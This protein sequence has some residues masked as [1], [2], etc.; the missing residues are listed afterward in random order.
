MSETAT[1]GELTEEQTNV[2][3]LLRI[4]GM[5]VA[6]PSLSLGFVFLLDPEDHILHIAGLI[7]LGLA[8]LL[9]TVLAPRL[10]V[11]WVDE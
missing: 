1:V 6:W 8:G 7:P 10:A 3:N 5:F 2:R 11:R 4:F 9:L